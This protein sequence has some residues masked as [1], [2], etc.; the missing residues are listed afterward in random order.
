MPWRKSFFFLS[1][2]E[3]HEKREPHSLAPCCLL[4]HARWNCS[5]HYMA[6]E[7]ANA[8]RLAELE[9]RRHLGPDAVTRLC[10]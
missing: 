2:I 9:V 4:A 5:T 8:L 7:G 3:S 1:F 10:I 6:M